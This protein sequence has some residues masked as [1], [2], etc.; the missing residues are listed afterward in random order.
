M[1]S[2]SWIGGGGIFS[3]RVYARTRLAVLLHVRT[4]VH[5]WPSLHLPAVRNDRKTRHVS[6][7]LT[8][9]STSSNN[10]PA[11]ATMNYALVSGAVV[12]VGVVEEPT[13]DSQNTQTLLTNTFEH[14]AARHPNPALQQEQQEC[15]A[16]LQQVAAQQEE[17]GVNTSVAQSRSTKRSGLFGFLFGNKKKQRRQ[18]EGYDVSHLNPDEY[19]EYYHDDD[20]DEQRTSVLC[21]D[22]I[23]DTSCIPKEA[24]AKA[25]FHLCRRPTV[26]NVARTTTGSDSTASIS[27]VDL[28]VVCELGE[29]GRVME[30]SDR[31][32]LQDYVGT[33]D[34]I[35][36]DVSRARALLLGND[37]L[38]AVSWGLPDGIIVLYHRHEHLWVSIAVI[39]P[40]R[41]VTDNIQ[42]QQHSSDV[43]SS[44]LVTDL[45]AMQ[46]QD[47]NNATGVVTTLCISRLGGYIEFI[48]LPL[49]ALLQQQQKQHHHHL[50]HFHK[51]KRQQQHY[52][53]DLVN[54][55]TSNTAMTA[56]T[57]AD[58]HVDVTCLE[59]WR[60]TVTS[61]TEWDTDAFPKTPPAEYVLVASGGTS[62][63]ETQVVSF[64]GVSIVFPENIQVEA[65]SIHFAFLDGINLGRMGAG[66]TVFS[67]EIMW[68]CWRKPRRVRLR[69]KSEPQHDAM[70]MDIEGEVTHE[71]SDEHVDS[72]LESKRMPLSTL[73]TA[74]PIVQMRLTSR[75]SQQA[76]VLAALDGNGGVTFIDCTMVI[77][78]ASHDVT[79]DKLGD[80]SLIQ[81][82]CR[83]PSK[84][85]SPTVDIGWLN[86]D[87]PN[88]V[89][90]EVFYDDGC[91]PSLSLVIFKPRMLQV[92]SLPL[93]PLPEN[94]SSNNARV[95]YSLDLPSMS[96]G[97]T[98]FGSRAGQG[99]SFIAFKATENRRKLLCQGNLERLDSSTVI[100]MLVKAAKYAEAI[101]AAK[102]MN[103]PDSSDAIQLCHRQLWERDGSVE[104]LSAVTDDDYVVKQAFAIFDNK[105]DLPMGRDLATARA[106]CLL[107]L[108]R[109]SGVERAEEVTLRL[110]ALE[111]KVSTYILLCMGN[112]AI[113]QLEQ[114]REKFLRV[115]LAR[116]A[117]AF[118]SNG[119]ISAL[120]MILFR[121]RPELLPCQLEVLDKLPLETPTDSFAH[122]LP[123]P[124][125][126]R[127][128]FH[129]GEHGIDGLRQWPLMAHYME[130]TYGVR[131]LLDDKDETAVLDRCQHFDDEG[132]ALQETDV[133][134][135]YLIRAKRVQNEIGSVSLLRNFLELASQRLGV[136]LST[137]PSEQMDPEVFELCS[138]YTYTMQLNRILTA[139][140]S[141]ST[142]GKLAADALASM[143]LSDIGKMSVDDRVS[144]ILGPPNDPSAVLS[145]F[146]NGSMFLTLGEQ[147]GTDECE[148]MIDSSV[149]EYC[150]G[151]ISQSVIE[152]GEIGGRKPQQ[153]NALRTALDVCTEIANASRSTIRRSNRV[154]KESTTLENL[155]VNAAYETS[156]VCKL[157]DLGPA[158][159]RHMV[160][161]IWECFECLPVRL[162]SDNAL[163]S[164]AQTK[165][166]GLYKNLVVV[167]IFSRWS[168]AALGF[169]VDLNM[170]KN[171]D[172]G[173]ERRV[174]VALGVLTEMCQSFCHQVGRAK[175]V[176]ASQAELD[177][178]RDFISDIDQLDKVG[179]NGTLPMALT[180]QENLI[181]PFLRQEKFHLIDPLADFIN[182][183]E[184]QASVLAFVNEAMFSDGDDA[185]STAGGRTS[186]DRVQAA[187]NCQ[188][189]L[190]PLFPAL[191][192]EFVSSRRYL[193]A[194]SFINRMMAGSNE[195]VSPSEV[196]D[197]APLDTIESLLRRNP[198]CI[199]D[200]CR[201]WSDPAF[202]RRANETICRHYCSM[203]HGTADDPAHSAALPV[204]PGSAIYHLASLLGL[205][206]PSALLVVKSR[207]VYHAILISEFAAAAA[208][209]TTM[210]NESGASWEEPAV[211][212]CIVDAVARV[213]SL[214]E[215][216][217]TQTKLALCNAVFQRDRGTLSVLDFQAY[218]TVLDSFVVLENMTSRRR[219]QQVDSPQLDN[220]ADQRR[221]G[222]EL[223]TVNDFLVFRA[224]GVVAKTAKNVARHAHEPVN[225]SITKLGP[226]E[227][228]GD[229]VYQD[230]LT[231]YST[232]MRELFWI[233]RGVSAS[234]KVDD[235]LL[236]TLGRLLGFWC[237]AD[238]L[239]IRPQSMPLEPERADLNDVL[240]LGISLLLHTQDREALVSCIGELE[241]IL[242]RETVATME[243]AAS[244]AQ[245]DS[246]APDPEIVRTL[247]SRGYSE[248]GARRAAVMT[249]NESAQVALVWAVSHT[250]DEGFDDPMVSVASDNDSSASGRVDQNMVLCLNESLKLANSCVSRKQTLHSLLPAARSPTSLLDSATS[251]SAGGEV[252]H[253]N[254]HTQKKKKAGGESQKRVAR[255]TLPSEPVSRQVGN[256]P[257][258]H[259][260]SEQSNVKPSGVAIDKPM[261]AAKPLAP[262]KP[263]RIPQPS[264]KQSMDSEASK[265]KLFLP[266]VAK[267]GAEAASPVVETSRATSRKVAPPKS[268]VPPPAE[269]KMPPAVS[270]P[271][272]SK[273]SGIAP[274]AKPKLASVL[275]SKSRAAPRS[276]S[277][278]ATT[279]KAPPAST[280]V[281]RLST[282]R[283]QHKDTSTGTNL[284]SYERQRLIAE[285][286]RMLREARASRSGADS[287]T[288]STTKT[289]ANTATTTSRY[290]LRSRV[291]VPSPPTTAEATTIRAA[292]DSVEDTAPSTVPTPAAPAENAKKEEAEDESD[293][294]DFDD[295]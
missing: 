87:M 89:D 258:V 2:S 180:L 232:D 150:A 194:A 219:K 215:Y 58:Y 173:R 9:T 64:W 221:V 265:S 34:T 21:N 193:D 56:L 224:V 22:S 295:F 95:A 223:P 231:Q 6:A 162:M 4:H 186:G 261:T 51:R 112:E 105:D 227:S 153:A 205:E 113:P 268:R 252:A 36:Y 106:A 143:S 122:L 67:S 28:G 281:D 129:T 181:K 23:L 98:I 47:P 74:M 196:R 124:R 130:S 44:M 294:W 192:S 126:G 213:V 107:A 210:V 287:K 216:D 38:F 200:G 120:T 172:K 208:V 63:N 43:D 255:T 254:G 246:V 59:L 242:S 228:L 257:S 91:S 154:I 70:S 132:G 62:S 177:L 10:T 293:G 253:Q 229:R 14:Y 40:T 18:D 262:T 199:L 164:E 66:V 235:P 17:H 209:C 118:A 41:A 61:D 183:D 245:P 195:I 29:N 237:I 184:V 249:G 240:G 99:I 75:E 85:L 37:L 90:G 137:S 125:H 244:A 73:S 60:T 206:G 128:S 24:Y 271:M 35:T 218:E 123:V 45:V 267:G 176:V 54:I 264:G 76:V 187:I 212:E 78:L 88:K 273:P 207:V 50:P 191:S 266:A 148:R 269:K 250:L 233:L 167:D 201:D 27:L 197:R 31:V 25:R 135:W 203:Q 72:N 139:T 288:A 80:E 109:V 39:S 110:E 292:R 114:F 117:S 278:P 94:G 234:S 71:A 55:S 243:R 160:D 7:A 134:K 131:L 220:R 108:E 82:R 142:A 171:R 166:D 26:P 214:S 263:S 274:P 272:T 100:V 101:A 83:L 168:P 178:L 190:G 141:A 93:S 285:G 97:A 147:A 283:S 52:A 68:K 163:R 8:M 119:D 42:Q 121:H 133:C 19:L 116:L 241:G 136:D 159:C 188:D 79:E 211:A 96:H 182:R 77:A 289:S 46:V 226:P 48:I 259:K 174:A 169:L 270:K 140:P 179:F 84:S 138:M 260:S 103:V 239:R 127:N 146:R 204:L 104:Q 81:M 251:T 290:P 92:M 30:T 57:T 217:D 170:A 156:R 152:N 279:S 185:L 149:S 230:I 20:D 202:S 161:S 1:P 248:N 198:G 49:D 15:N 65:P 69:K 256:G 286:R 3:E 155:V 238:A 277:T 145:K 11:T 275:P 33:D 151:A 16:L 144:L 280:T 157:V 115:S 175:G 291:S 247:I 282:L 5:V 158:D 225:Q 222:D 284:A 86:A 111:A 13:R 276:Q 189:V 165:V 53:A 236:L 12:D 102:T 32:A